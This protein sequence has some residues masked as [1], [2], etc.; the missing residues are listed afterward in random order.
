[1]RQKRGLKLQRQ[2]IDNRK[3]RINP[4]VNARSSFSWQVKK[5]CKR[6]RNWKLNGADQAQTRTV[7]SETTAHLGIGR[8]VRGTLSV[9]IVFAKGTN[10]RGRHP[11]QTWRF[12]LPRRRSSSGMRQAGT[13]KAQ[14]AVGSLSNENRVLRRE[15][16]RR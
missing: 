2:I 3:G 16:I 1:M 8:S 7:G 4:L 14:A 5:R 10:L 9:G 11:P 6:L 13:R 12:L 15:R